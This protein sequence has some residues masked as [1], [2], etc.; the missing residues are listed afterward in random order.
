MGLNQEFSHPVRNCDES[1]AHDCHFIK[2]FQNQ[3]QDAIEVVI[4]MCCLSSSDS[5]PYICCHVI[6]SPFPPWTS[7]KGLKS[8]LNEGTW[9]IY[10]SSQSL[11]DSLD[12][13]PSEIGAV[14]FSSD[15]PFH[16]TH[17][18]Y[19]G[20]LGSL[21]ICVSNQASLCRMNLKWSSVKC[22]P[23][24]LLRMYLTSTFFKWSLQG[25]MCQSVQS[26]AADT[27]LWESEQRIIK[28]IPYT[29]DAQCVQKR[30]DDC[31]LFYG[32][33]RQRRA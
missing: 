23:T 18:I 2:T 8:T 5:V 3:G 32:P 16:K 1:Q 24:S 20:N 10:L 29:E 26:N 9:P 7:I 33:A 19:T 4:R 27:K 28:S 15:N 6:T 13:Q 25:N 21:I 14:K 22:T 31:F 11:S 17:D 30:Y 12:V